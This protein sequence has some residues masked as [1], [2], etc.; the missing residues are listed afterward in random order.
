METNPFSSHQS[1]QP[2]SIIHYNSYSSNF[3][4]AITDLITQFQSWM[5][6]IDSIL[7]CKWCVISWLWESVLTSLFHFLW[8]TFGNEIMFISFQINKLPNFVRLDLRNWCRF[9][10]YVPY[11]SCLKKRTVTIHRSGL[12]C[13]I[14]LGTPS[15]LH[16][17]YVAE[18]RV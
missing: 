13:F 7:F 10:F 12:T 3:C 18:N 5:N 16:Y 17:C 11:F 6:R 4:L 8:F 2:N 15:L 14:F 1:D 9:I